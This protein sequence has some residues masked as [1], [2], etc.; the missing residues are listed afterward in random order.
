MS[1]IKIQIE[2]FIWQSRRRRRV[3]GRKRPLFCL[4][5][6]VQPIF[7]N[8][9]KQRRLTTLTKTALIGMFIVVQF[10][11]LNAQCYLQS[12]IN[13]SLFC[14]HR[15]TYLLLE[16]FNRTLPAGIPGYIFGIFAVFRL[17]L[18]LHFRRNNCLCV[19][20]EL[21]KQLLNSRVLQCN[22]VQLERRRHCR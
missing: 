2:K 5:L 14:A 18:A 12:L 19:C 20:I 16:F 8:I 13:A 17:P 7:I 4:A 11:M 21:F 10:E 1:A 15:C 6:V 3:R 9:T 22:C